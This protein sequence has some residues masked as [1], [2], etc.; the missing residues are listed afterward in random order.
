MRVLNRVAFG[1]VDSSPRWKFALPPGLKLA[2][3]KGF[4]PLDGLAP[5]ADFKSVAFDHLSHVSKKE[6]Q[7]TNQ[8]KGR[9]LGFLFISQHLAGII[10]F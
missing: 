1:C 7:P 6:A 5:S 4:E 2:E 10:I 8:F 3:T 9:L